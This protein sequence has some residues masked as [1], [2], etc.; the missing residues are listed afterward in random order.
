MNSFSVAHCRMGIGSI[1]SKTT[2]DSESVFRSGL[3]RSELT[4][5]TGLADAGKE[6]FE[7]LCWHCF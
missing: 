7:V 3:N 4:G 6:F 5:L 2:R 1:K